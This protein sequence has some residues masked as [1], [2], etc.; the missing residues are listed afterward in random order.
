MRKVIISP[1]VLETYRKF[2][3]NWANGFITQESVITAIKGE[4]EWSNEMNFGSAIHA[5]I[6]HGAEKFYN[7][8][9]SKYHIKQDDMPGS[10]VLTA[11]EIK[12]IVEYKNKYTLMRHEFRAKHK[13]MLSNYEVLLTMRIDGIH[14]LNIHEHKT[15]TRPPDY[16]NFFQ[17]VQW[18]CYYLA[19]QCSQ[20]IYNV[21]YW[22]EKDDK[23]IITPYQYTFLPYVGIEQDVRLLIISYIEF[24]EKHN[25]MEYTKSKYEPEP[26]KDTGATFD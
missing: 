24:C 10:I 19:T 8:N 6:E 3:D 7:S 25:L 11:E 18:K 15:A 22:V 12:P 1:S 2:K 16:T 23:K 20:I 4:T 14:G 21:F 17:S 26:I 5:I 9:D 13:I